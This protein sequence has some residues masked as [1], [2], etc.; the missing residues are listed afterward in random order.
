VLDR[1]ALLSHGAGDVLNVERVELNDDDGLAV[2]SAV[3]GEVVAIPLRVA[4]GVALDL[5]GDGLELDVAVFVLD[6]DH[7]DAGRWGVLAGRR[8]VLGVGGGRGQ[9]HS[10][11]E[12]DHRE[13]RSEGGDEAAAAIER[14]VGVH[15]VLRVESRCGVRRR[16][17]VGVT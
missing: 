17:N 13:R 4:V 16:E 7:V 5:A 3:D 15:G 8:V 10:K 1:E 6:L 12:G 11:R 2:E 14:G 9:K